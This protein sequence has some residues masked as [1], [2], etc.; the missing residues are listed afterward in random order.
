MERK[1]QILAMDETQERSNEV[2]AALLSALEE[3]KPAPSIPQK[4]FTPLSKASQ[5]VYNSLLNLNITPVPTFTHKHGVPTGLFRLPLEIRQQIYGLVTGDNTTFKISEGHHK[6]GSSHGSFN[7]GPTSLLQTCRQIYTEASTRIYTRNTFNFQH[8]NDF[9]A[10]T[11]AV[12]PVHLNQITCLDFDMDSI[13]RVD[14][15]PYDHQC[16]RYTVYWIDGVKPQWSHVWSII[17]AMDNL[18]GLKVI[19]QD[20]GFPEWSGMQC[21]CVHESDILAPLLHVKRKLDF[22]EVDVPWVSLKHTSISPDAP[23]RLTRRGIKMP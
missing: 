14:G 8:H 4:I 6:V 13:I 20:P 15:T 1:S 18:M 22:F 9:L 11:H 17:A 12:N 2:P 3:S 16:P 21:L 10:F 19:L 7:N 23:F 5:V